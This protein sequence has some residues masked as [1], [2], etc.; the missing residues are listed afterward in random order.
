LIEAGGARGGA[1]DLTPERQA[2]AVGRLGRLFAVALVLGAAVQGALEVKG[3]QGGLGW[4]AAFAAAAVVLLFVAPALADVLAVPG[5]L[6]AEVRRGNLAAAIVAAGNRVAVGVVLSHCFYGADL[7]TFL[8]SLAFVGIGFATL[9]GLQALYRR[10]TR[11]ADDQEVKGE[12]AAAA[13]SFAGVT[14][15]LAII[16]GHATWGS[17]AGW[18]ASLRGYGAGLALALGLYPVRQLLVKRLLLGLPLALR[19]GALDRA[20]AQERNIVVGAVEGT[21]YVATAI[22]ITGILP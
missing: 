7:A 18:A 17:F 4:T 11:Y 9:L 21:A 15:A 2:R 22:L 5:G 3:W 19:G 16:V 12:N 14:V 13:L 1:A 20:V 10:L 6:R 8:V